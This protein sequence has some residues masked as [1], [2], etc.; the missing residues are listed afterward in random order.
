MRI[1]VIGSGIAG[2]TSAWSLGA[3]HEVHVLEAHRAP[4]MHAHAVALGAEAPQ[5]VDVPLRVFYPA[6]Y[7]TLLRLYAGAGIGSECVDASG[8]YARL[9]AP[10]AYFR[11]HNLRLPGRSVPWVPPRTLATGAGRRILLDYAHFT[12]AARRWRSAARFPTASL[13]EHLR[14]AGYSTE[15]VDGLLLPSFAAIATCSHEQARAY[16]LEIVARYFTGGFL[17]AC[18]KRAR[19]GATAVA[20][21]LLS[22]AAQVRFGVA[23]GAVRPVGAGAEVVVDGAV[24]RFDRVVVATQANQAA[25]LVAAALPAEAERLGRFRYEPVRVVMHRDPSLMPP[26][27]RDWAPVNLLTDAAADRPM[28]TI[29]VNAVVP[30]L[31]TQAPAFQTVHPLREPAPDTVIS[32]ARFERPLVDGASADAWLRL[33]AATAE[34]DRRVWFCGS[35]ASPGVPL[36]ESAAASALRAAAAIDPGC[37]VAGA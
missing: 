6:Y 9:G 21:A 20:R 30:G 35:Y 25:R 36:L 34:A 27:R 16:P 15:F 29:W 14:E 1:A 2:L 23:V 12:R 7:P 11:Y 13:G 26:D 28:A 8:S 5:V 3:R 19:G 24:E 32:E 22:R 18:V 17:F 31:A 37:A 4:G 10:R 33:E